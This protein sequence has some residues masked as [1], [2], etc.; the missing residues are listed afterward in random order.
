MPSTFKLGCM[1]P[2]VHINEPNFVVDQFTSTEFFQE[3][4]MELRDFSV[5]AKSEASPELH[6]KIKEYLI[7]NQITSFPSD[8]SD[9][10]VFAQIK[11]KY[12]S[13]T[14]ILSRL[15]GRIAELRSKP[16]ESSE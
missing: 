9:D 11:S 14:S 1:P 10:D 13:T 3:D 15:K 12:D 4:G 5:F 16:S 6:E 2:T 7:E 8:I